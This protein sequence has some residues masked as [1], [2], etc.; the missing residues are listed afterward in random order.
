MCLCI[1]VVC[2]CGR[3]ILG[4][5]VRPLG[6]PGHSGTHNPITHTQNTHACVHS[7]IAL[8]FA[9]LPSVHFVCIGVGAVLSVACDLV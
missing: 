4:A 3:E 9:L 2:V 8:S 6:L 7:H 5:A 1:G